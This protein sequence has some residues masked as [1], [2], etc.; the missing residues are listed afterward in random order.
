VYQTSRTSYGQRTA[1]KGILRKM[2]SF[3]YIYIFL[4]LSLACVLK[5]GRV[6]TTMVDVC[7]CRRTDVEAA[8][9]SLSG[10]SLLLSVSVSRI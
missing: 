9:G 1:V 5:R 3:I 4:F 6:C 7:F 2:L 10:E 8:F